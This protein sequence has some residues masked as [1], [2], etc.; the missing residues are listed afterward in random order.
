MILAWHGKVASASALWNTIILP[1]GVP[2]LQVSESSAG[3]QAVL[4]LVKEAV[5]TGKPSRGLKDMH[6]E[7]GMGQ[8]EKNATENPRW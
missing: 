3:H 8:M 1:R 5:Q 7:G 6:Q 2:R 4:L